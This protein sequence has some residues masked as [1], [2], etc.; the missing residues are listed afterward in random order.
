MFIEPEVVLP[1]RNMGDYYGRRV[2]E[3]RAPIK[4]LKVARI[5]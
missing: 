2:V 4:V 5:K 3:T 1:S